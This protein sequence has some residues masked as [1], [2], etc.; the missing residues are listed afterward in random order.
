MRTF[1]A[2]A[3]I[4]LDSIARGALAGDAM[5]KKAPIEMLRSGTVHRGKYLVLVGGAVAA[6]EESFEEGL[7]VAG[8]RLV[9]RVILPDVHEQVHDCVLG[10]RR[11]E[12][13]DALGVIETSTVAATIHA[14]DAGVKGAAVT[15]KEIRLADGLGGKGIVLFTG[16]VADVEAAVAIG[17]G[18]LDEHRCDVCTTVIPSLHSE[19]VSNMVETSRFFFAGREPGRSTGVTEER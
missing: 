3:L 5:V 19:M 8:D 12:A 15:I 10:A 13:D 4:E 6:V 1:P 14:A 18:V 16:K 11:A 9:D 2:I 17:T 7:R